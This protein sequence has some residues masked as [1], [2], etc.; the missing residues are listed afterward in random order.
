VTPAS[1]AIGYAATLAV[2]APILAA[3]QCGLARIFGFVAGKASCRLPETFAHHRK[4]SLGHTPGHLTVVRET[5]SYARGVAA[6]L[7]PG[8]VASQSPCPRMVR[9]RCPSTGLQRSQ[10]KERC[11]RSGELSASSMLMTPWCPAKA[12]PAAFVCYSCWQHYSHAHT[13]LTSPDQLLWG[14]C[15][16]G[17]TYACPTV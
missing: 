8:L 11:V 16:H 6:S 10:H 5:A 15:S 17:R 14:A 3:Q 7:S 13:A 2:C 9:C 4:C 1:C 12:L